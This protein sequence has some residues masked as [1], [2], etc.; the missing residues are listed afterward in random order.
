M[1]P[2]RESEARLPVSVLCIVALCTSI[3]CTTLG[4]VP[5]SAQGRIMQVAVIDFANNSKV[6]GRVYSKMATDAVVVELVRSGK[7]TA[8]TSEMVES[9]M[10]ALGYQP[11]LTPTLEHRLGQELGADAVVGG[12]IN[13]IKVDK[14]K[15]V[16]EV[17]LVVRMLDVASGELINGA[18]AVGKSHSRVGYGDEDQLLI[19]AIQD[20]AR[21]AVDMMVR[22]ILPE[23]TVLNPIGANEV[24]LN[25]GSQEGI[26]PGMEMIVLR[27]SETG[28]DEVVG[29]I[30]ITKVTDTDAVATVIRAP[31][32]VKPEDRARA[33]FQMPTI[34]E[35]VLG[36]PVRPSELKKGISKGTKL[37]FAL[38]GLLAVGLIFNGGGNEHESIPG[39]TAQAG[40]SGDIITPD[41]GSDVGV[42]VS[43][44]K[45]RNIRTMDI[46]EYHVW[47]NNRGTNL[48]SAGA[49]T[50]VPIATPQFTQAPA[51]AGWDHAITLEPVGISHN[52]WH[53]ADPDTHELVDVSNDELIPPLEIGKPSQY[54]VS[55]LYKRI[56]P[57]D[58]T[59]TYWETSNT[60]SGVATCLNRPVLRPSFTE[61]SDLSNI[62]F[63]WESCGGA[64]R[65]VIEV[66]RTDSFERDKTWV[67]TIVQR[68][69]ADGIPM[70]CNLVN[71]IMDANG[72]IVKELAGVS[73]GDVL[74]W[75][76]G[77]RNSA[78][79]PGPFPAGP[80][81]QADGPKN[82]RYIYSY[83]ESFVV[84]QPPSPG[85][86]S[87][88]DSGGD[89][90]P[91][92]G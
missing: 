39:V 86:T 24:L 17:R 76:V 89:L 3:I 53:A 35:G 68:T 54:W 40:V 38:A 69:A 51:F 11:P 47:R 14:D 65:Y 62:T 30:K 87:G 91:V 82:T 52:E 15:R 83:P 92:P 6:P 31:K 84:E 70:S 20:A 80:S 33:I 26:E 28:E 71:K 81:P 44:N 29:R 32:G 67:Y 59:V 50:E 21:N 18:I 73:E 34:K 63:E 61:T 75:R 41:Y 78:D 60:G 37:L 43:W 74:Y 23:A 49:G 36:E 66:S 25:K 4:P 5:A 88:G 42:M 19:E 8:F 9:K 22:Y 77:A 10:Q 56:S 16:A 58:G 64:D 2:F 85:G 46:I 90:P 72:V 7:F 55:C 1:K 48:G 79:R 12:E 57:R 13:A 27:R 45:P